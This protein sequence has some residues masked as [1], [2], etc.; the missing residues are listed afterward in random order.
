MS[1]LSHVQS[2]QIQAPSGRLVA[3]LPP[4]LVAAPTEILDIPD[5]EVVTGPV[6]LEVV[7]RHVELP[8]EAGVT[9]RT[10][11][12]ARSA[13]TSAGA[14]PIRPAARRWATSPS[15]AAHST[16]RR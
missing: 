3:G 16:P 13:S 1:L 14:S 7:L 2:F 9:A 4:D 11:S 12:P 15:S 5:T 10:T 8:T 6:D